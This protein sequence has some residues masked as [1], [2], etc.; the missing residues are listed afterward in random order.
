[1]VIKKQSLLCAFL[2]IPWFTFSIGVKWPIFGMIINVLRVFSLMFAL[3]VYLSNNKKLKSLSEIK[4]F[5][6]VILFFTILLLSTLINEQNVFYSFQLMVYGIWPFIIVSILKNNKKENMFFLEGIFMAFAFLIIVN[7]FLIVV[8]PNGI[9]TTFSSNTVT[10]YY[11][12]GGKNQSVAPLMTALVFF[13]EYSIRKYNK[14]VPLVCFLIFIVLFEI[15]T[16]GSGTGLIATVMIIFLSLLHIFRKKEISFKITLIVIVASFF[17]LVVFRLQEILAFFIQGVLHKSL[18]LSNR[19][20][21]WDAAIEKI[22]NNWL[23]GN[24]VGSSLSGKIDLVLSYA[25]KDTFAHDLYLDIMIMGG[26]LALICFIIIVFFTG[27]HYQTS[28]NVSNIGRT[29]VWIGVTAYLF[30]SILDIYIG[31]YCLF[32][33]IAYIVTIPAINNENTVFKVS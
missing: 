27:K 14:I 16:G 25:T 1:M 15:W 19:I 4:S 31:N 20:Y 26:T 23:Y 13:I 17:L 29:T 30:A 21:I 5:R 2:L 32:I 3:L 10:K 33:M 28:S 7:L 8:Y 22:K 9:Y 12:F 6:F 24:G 11:L 18:T